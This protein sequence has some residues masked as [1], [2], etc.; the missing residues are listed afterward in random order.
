[1]CSL[2]AEGLRRNRK[3]ILRDLDPSKSW[4]YLYQEGIFDLDDIEEVKAEKT[5]KKKAE[6][7][8]EKVEH[9]GPDGIAV[10]AET[11][12]ESQRHLFD[13]LHRVNDTGSHGGQLKAGTTNL[14]SMFNDDDFVVVTEKEWFWQSTF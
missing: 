1:M 8:L 2:L 6:A 5:R 10:F 7:L 11:L 14:Y 9:S 4:N 13:L 3:A 12:R